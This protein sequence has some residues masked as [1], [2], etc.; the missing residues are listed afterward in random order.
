MPCEHLVFRQGMLEV[1]LAH[2]GCRVSDE[3]AAM[4]TPMHERPDSASELIGHLF[5]DDASFIRYVTLGVVGD[6]W[7]HV[8]C[9]DGLSGY[10]EARHFG[11]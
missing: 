6:E 11:D 10:V 7:F 1:E 8:L 3:S 4:G 9:F 5:M 2:P